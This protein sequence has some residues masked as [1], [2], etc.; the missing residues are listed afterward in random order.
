MALV[1]A[2]GKVMVAASEAGSV[3]LDVV[4][5][6]ER[7]SS[8]NFGQSSSFFFAFSLLALLPY[9]LLLSVHVLVSSV[10]MTLVLSFRDIFS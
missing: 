2:S 8:D 7:S 3:D 9:I 10:Q 6:W 4:E 1:F 5:T